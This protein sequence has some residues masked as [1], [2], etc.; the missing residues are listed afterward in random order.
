MAAREF[1]I[2]EAS[3]GCNLDGFGKYLVGHHMHVTN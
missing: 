3:R 1:W 2:Y